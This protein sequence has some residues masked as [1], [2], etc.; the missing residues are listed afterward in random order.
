MTST[1]IFQSVVSGVVATIVLDLWAQLLRVTVGLP[2]PDWGVNGRWFAHLPKGRF[3]HEGLAET[4]PVPNEAV[5]G[6]AGHYIIGIAY[7]FAYVGLIVLGLD[8]QPSLL[9]GLVF[10]AVS[11]VL[12]WFVMMPGIGK[13]MMAS[14]ADSPATACFLAL[15]AHIVFG[16]GLY[17]GAALVA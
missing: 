17:A 13:G 15:V 2:A 10:G 3:V 12:A 14:K 16:L 1:L 6:W 11:V 8:S 7:G 5:I 9:N 4:P